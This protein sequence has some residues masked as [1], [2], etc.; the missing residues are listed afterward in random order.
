[1]QIIVSDFLI[2]SRISSTPAIKL[3]ASYTSSGIF[4]IISSN[5]DALLPFHLISNAEPCEAKKAPLMMI[6]AKSTGFLF[7]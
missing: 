4:R 7:R 5:G 1:M 2:L 3:G 6:D